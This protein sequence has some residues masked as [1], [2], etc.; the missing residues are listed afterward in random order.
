MSDLRG[1]AANCLLRANGF[2]SLGH[3]RRNNTR[4]LQKKQL[5]EKDEWAKMYKFQHE[6]GVVQGASM[7]A[8]SSFDLEGKLALSTRSDFVFTVAH[9]YAKGNVQT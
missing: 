5:I 1:K 7:P 4:T 2:L 9:V 3:R 6:I 8:S